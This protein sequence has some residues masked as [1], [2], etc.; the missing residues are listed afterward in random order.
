MSFLNHSIAALSK[1]SG[2]AAVEIAGNYFSFSEFDSEEENGKDHTNSEHIKGNKWNRTLEEDELWHRK[3]GNI[4]K[5]IRLPISQELY[6]YVLDVY[7]PGSSYRGVNGYAYDLKMQNCCKA[8]VPFIWCA[9]QPYL[10]KLFDDPGS[11]TYWKKTFLDDETNAHR[12]VVL[13]KLY[14]KHNQTN[15]GLTPFRLISNSDEKDI[16]QNWT[17]FKLHCAALADY[18]GS[19]RAKISL[20]EAYPG[21]GPDDFLWHPQRFYHYA[22]FARAVVEKF[23]STNVEIPSLYRTEWGEV[24][25]VEDFTKRYSEEIT[26][27]RHGVRRGVSGDLSAKKLT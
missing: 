2:H 9:I 1:S 4:R 21:K 7:N 5:V 11:I 20:K 26:Y 10:M 17:I 23:A 8:L 3:R 24:Q 22:Q 16:I 19:S 25:S 18:Y 12:Y 15:P 14:Y 27:D 6:P 13:K